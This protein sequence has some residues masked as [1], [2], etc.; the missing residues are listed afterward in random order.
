MNVSFTHCHETES[1]HFLD[2]TLCGSKGNKIEILPYS[3]P[4]GRNSLLLATSC[5]AP[6]TILNLPVGEFLR[7]KRNCSSTSEFQEHQ[8]RVQDKLPVR[9]YL[10]WSID[11]AITRVSNTPRE[12]LLKRKPK[13]IIPG[14]NKKRGDKNNDYYPL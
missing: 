3:K 9:H 4:M 14:K 6:H 10:K 8:N 7:T 11:R 1:I 2:K 12:P 5:H 13:D